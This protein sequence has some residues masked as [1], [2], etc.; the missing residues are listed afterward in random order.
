M[1]EV[2]EEWVKQCLVDSQVELAGDHKHAGSRAI[3]HRHQSTPW[4]I[5]PIVELQRSDVF[6][7]SE[8]FVMK[9]S[10]LKVQR[11]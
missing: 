6:D 10:Q 8:S 4:G 3:V 7:G 2:K 1:S 5:R 9:A 11:G